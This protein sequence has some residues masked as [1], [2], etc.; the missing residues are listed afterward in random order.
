[1]KPEVK[2]IALIAVAILVSASALF[3]WIRYTH[4]R[5]AAEEA[6]E[7]TFSWSVVAPQG[8]SRE[9]TAAPELCR[10][11]GDASFGCVDRSDCVA[12]ARYAKSGGDAL[13]QL[14]NLGRFMLVYDALMANGKLI[15]FTEG[16]SVYFLGSEGGLVKIRRPRETAVYWTYGPFI[17]K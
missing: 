5:L 3:A 15:E 14:E 6:N 13:A 11:V 8:D 10:I 16:E 2:R 9:E 4:D 17:G 1:M 12:L 7:P